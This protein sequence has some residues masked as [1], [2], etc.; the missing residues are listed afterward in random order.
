MM[1]TDADIDLL[2]NARDKIAFERTACKVRKDLVPMSAIL[3]CEKWLRR[4]AVRRTD[5]KKFGSRESR[6]RRDWTWIE[7]RI[8]EWAFAVSS[9][10]RAGVDFS[11]LGIA[12]YLSIL[13]QRSVDEIVEKKN[14]RFGIKGL[15]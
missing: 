14:V 6:V 10:R 2:L 7:E 4:R 13:L 1:M 9:E 5:Y 11:F 12:E 8:L 15:F 3:E